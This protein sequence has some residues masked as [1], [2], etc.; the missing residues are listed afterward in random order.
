MMNK[1]KKIFRWL[2]NPKVVQVLLWIAPIIIG[3]IADGSKNKT[4][5]D[6]RKAVRAKRAK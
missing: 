2:S 4:S 6:A 1:M 3:W 5:A